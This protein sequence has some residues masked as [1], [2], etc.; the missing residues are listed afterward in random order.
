M[1]FFN[2]TLH[3][4]SVNTTPHRAHFTHANIFSR[5]VQG[6]ERFQTR[7]GMCPLENNHSSFSCFM[8]YPQSSWSD[9]PP[10]PFPPH[11]PSLLYPSHGAEQPHDP[12]TEGQS[13]RLAAQSSLTGYEPNA[14]VEVSS[15]EVTLVLQ[16]SRRTSFCSVYNSGGDVTTTLVSSEVD[17]RQSMGML[18]SLLLTQNSETSAAIARNY[19]STR[20]SSVSSSSHPRSAGRLVGI[21]SH[22]RTSSNDPRNIQETHSARE[23]IRTADQEVRDH[24]KLRADK[25]AE[26]E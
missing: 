5:V 2:I 3:G 1:L 21:Y 4:E 19:R 6:P 13:G 15:A 7:F 18:A 9:L 23:R 25:P 8:S 11:I 20:E 16:P 22:K 14:T 26:G 24:L 10:S 17:E 12:W